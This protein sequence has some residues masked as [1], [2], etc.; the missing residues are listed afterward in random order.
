VYFTLGVACKMFK[1]EALWG[2]IL[3]NKDLNKTPVSR[4]FVFAG[5]ILA[6]GQN[7]IG[8]CMLFGLLC[9]GGFR[10]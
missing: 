2:K 1:I 5:F 4:G 9:L 3:E 6:G 7:R 8:I 10:A